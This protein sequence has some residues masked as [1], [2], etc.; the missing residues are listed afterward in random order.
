MRSCTVCKRVKVDPC[1]NGK[2]GKNDCDPCK[3]KLLD[4]ILR[5]RLC[6]DDACGKETKVCKNDCD[7]CKEK[8]LDK[9]FRKR[10]C[11]DNPCADSAAPAKIEAK[12]AK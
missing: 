1:D 3:E 4:K 12:P 5:K 7:P 8:L 10:L 11:C 2:C 6:C 9:I